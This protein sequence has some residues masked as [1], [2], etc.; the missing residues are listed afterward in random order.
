MKDSTRTKKSRRKPFFRFVKWILRLFTKTPKVINYNEGDI[1][2]KSIIISNHSGA[3]GPLFLE[4]YLGHYFVPWGTYEMNS[5]LK[6]RWKYLTQVY[7]TQKKHYSKFVAKLFA[8]PCVFILKGFYNGIELLPTYKDYRLKHTFELSFKRLDNNQSI[9]IFPENSSTGYKEVLDQF[10]PGFVSLAKTYN[11]KRNCDLP[12]Y[13]VYLYKKKNVLLV[14]KS[15]SIR[16]LL[17]QGLT[18]EQIAEHFMKEV[19]KLR[20]EYIK[21]IEEKV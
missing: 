6:E 14:G 13:P 1:E 20:E 7:F 4:L 10:F 5:T 9:L 8:I 18:K 11:K 19:N 3:S 15:Q 16:P 2:D 17:E 12:I 21:S